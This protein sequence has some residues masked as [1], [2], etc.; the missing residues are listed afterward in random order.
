MIEEYQTIFPQFIKN[1]LLLSVILPKLYEAVEIWD[2][3][4][5]TVMI[6]I[7]IFPWYFF[8]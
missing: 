2:P 7:W 3:T 1:Y 5:D 4:K 8:L 6:H